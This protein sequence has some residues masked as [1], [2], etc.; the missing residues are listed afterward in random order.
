MKNSAYNNTNFKLSLLKLKTYRSGD[1]FQVAFIKIKNSY[2]SGESTMYIIPS[3]WNAH[4]Q[5]NI[6]INISAPLQTDL[7]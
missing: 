1:L 7:N 6:W 5:S 3:E 4:V 2:R